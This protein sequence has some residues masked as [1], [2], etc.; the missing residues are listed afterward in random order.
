[1]AGLI[2][3]AIASLDGYVADTDGDF[4]WCAP[5]EEVHAAVNELERPIGTHLYGRRMY[6]VLQVWDTMD[7][8]SEPPVIR[9]FAQIWGAADKIVYSRTLE[10]VSGARTRIERELDPDKLRRLKATSTRDL[11]IGGPELAAVALRAGLV[12]ELH[13]FLAPVVV[14]GGNPALPDGLH[15][16]L[17]LVGVRRFASG[18]VHLHHAVRRP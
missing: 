17:E 10:T 15:L 8:G 6:D 12:D 11:S 7:T 13:L 5:D 18:F 2:Y 16:D 3:A 1:M 4:G 9:D 14:G